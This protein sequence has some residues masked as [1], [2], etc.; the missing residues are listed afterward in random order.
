[1]EM[2]FPKRN[3]LPMFRNTPKRM[4]LMAASA[5]VFAGIAA[6]QTKVAVINV[7]SAVLQTAEIKKA[8]AALEAKY[9][10]KQAAIE[11]LRTDITGIQQKL[12]AGAGTHTPQ[13]QSELTLDA[14]RKQR[15]MQRK[16]QDFQEEFDAERNEILQKSGQQMAGVVKKLPK[17]AGWMWWSMFRARCISSRRSISR[18]MRWP[19]TTRLFPQNSFRG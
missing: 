1:M 15:E 4:I 14:Q 10:P 2:Q 19:P 7:Q 18:P 3:F 17:S 8:S 13:A 16:S 11:A 5:V 12:Q 6:A 9:K